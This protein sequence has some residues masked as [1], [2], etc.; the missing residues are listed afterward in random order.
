VA[1]LPQIAMVAQASFDT[2]LTAKAKG[3]PPSSLTKR[4]QLQSVDGVMTLTFSAIHYCRPESCDPANAVVPGTISITEKSVFFT[5]YGKDAETHGLVPGTTMKD[6]RTKK[7]DTYSLFN[8]KRECDRF[9]NE[10]Y[11]SAFLTFMRLALTD[12]PAAVKQ[13][14]DSSVQ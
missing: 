12:F 2:G 6:Q 5:P 10:A 11:D 8:E 3:G 14:Q 1:H 13:L 9:G 7:G 4:V